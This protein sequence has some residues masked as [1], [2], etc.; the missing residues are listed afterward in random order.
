V[1]TIQP[2]DKDGNQRWELADG[3]TLYDV[4]HLACRSAHWTPATANNWC[5]PA[6]ARTT[7]F[8]VNPGG[9][10]AR[11]ERLPQAG[12]HGSHRRRAARHSLSRNT[13]GASFRSAVSRAGGSQTALAQ[14][15]RGPEGDTR[16]IDSNAGFGLGPR[17]GEALG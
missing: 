2:K 14:T 13:Q 10:H 9:G 7:G 12:L 11:R 15:A 16:T 17:H 1:L 8:P 6:S 4:T 3:A 5:L